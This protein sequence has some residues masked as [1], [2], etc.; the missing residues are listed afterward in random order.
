MTGDAWVGVCVCGFVCVCLC[1]FVWLHI[2]YQ[3]S[4]S[5]YGVGPFWLVLT[6]SKVEIRVGF[7]VGVVDM[8]HVKSWIM[9]YVSTKIE[10]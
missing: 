8:F 10:I 1:V 3:N 5:P 6:T 7:R 2:E 9:Y 4:H